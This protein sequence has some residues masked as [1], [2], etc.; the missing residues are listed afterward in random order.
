M[1]IKSK[2]RQFN[3][4]LA[5]GHM[6]EAKEHILSGYGV[7]S[8]MELTEKQ[9]DELI[10]SVQKLVNRKHEDADKETRSWRHKCLRLVKEC[11]INTNDWNA[12]NDFLLQPRI[13]GRHLYDLSVEDLQVLHRKL[14][15]VRNNKIKKQQENDRLA[16][17]N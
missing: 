4:L 9:L 15:N 7:T 16:T 1:D 12:V 13:C 2:R 14:H 5:V 3:A 10:I 8:T 6:L 17:M 11:G